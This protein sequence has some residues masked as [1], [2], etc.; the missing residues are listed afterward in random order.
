MSKLLKD[1]GQRYKLCEET[2]A[3]KKS[4]NDGTPGP[5]IQQSNKLPEQG[6]LSNVALMKLMKLDRIVTKFARDIKTDKAAVLEYLIGP[7]KGR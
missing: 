7:D 5:R 4:Q 6:G 2:A 3:S 1:L